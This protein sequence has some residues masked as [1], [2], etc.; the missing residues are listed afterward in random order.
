V[1]EDQDFSDE[2]SLLGKSILDSTGILELVSFV[3]EAFEIKVEDDEVIPDNL[4]SV[5]KVMDFVSRKGGQPLES[6]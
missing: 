6:G 4:D 5:R 1:V 3:E 2:D